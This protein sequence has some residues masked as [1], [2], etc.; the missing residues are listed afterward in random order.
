M[1]PTVPDSSAVCLSCGMCCD[2]TLFE[3]AK[4]EP[5][6]LG[7]LAAHGIETLEAEGRL[8][9]RLGCPR[10]S[11]TCCTIYDDR[12]TICRTFQCKLLAELRSGTVT[13]G[14]ALEAVAEAKALLDKVRSQRPEAAAL[15]ERRPIAKEAAQWASL[16]DPAERLRVARLYLDIMALERHL[17]ARFRKEAPEAPA[18]GKV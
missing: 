9:F 7:R 10:L 2:G 1:D 12:F 14:E 5:A 13:V 16:S 3:R 18:A 17:G 6:E 4:A 8:F 11:G 15:R